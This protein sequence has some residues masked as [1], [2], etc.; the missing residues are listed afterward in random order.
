MAPTNN[1]TTKALLTMDRVSVFCSS[2][3]IALSGQEIWIP[4]NAIQGRV[5]MDS[6]PQWI[7]RF[8][9]TS[10]ISKRGFKL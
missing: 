1:T 5:E 10:S 6:P 3:I 9:N 7:A 4:P 2:R 8:A